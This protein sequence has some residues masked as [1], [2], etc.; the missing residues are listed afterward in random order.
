M[1]ESAADQAG[2]GSPVKPHRSPAHRCWSIAT[3]HLAVDHKNPVDQLVPASARKASKPSHC[4]LR[5]EAV[6]SGSKASAYW[7]SL[8]WIVC[9][10]RVNVSSMTR[11]RHHCSWQIRFMISSISMLGAIRYYS[12]PLDTLAQGIASRFLVWY[13]FGLRDRSAFHD[14]WCSR[15]S[16]FLCQLYS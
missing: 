10:F 5:Q 4:F 12:V 6:T 1:K 11:R 14:Q 7:A 8:G 9:Y 13:I 2:E 3:R 16:S 15:L